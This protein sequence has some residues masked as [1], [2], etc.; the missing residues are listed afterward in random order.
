MIQVCGYFL[1]DKVFKAS[2]SFPQGHNRWYKR[3]GSSA[4]YS[5]KKHP[6]YLNGILYFGFIIVVFFVP[7][8]LNAESPVQILIE[9]VKDIELENVRTALALP[10]GFV[11]DGTINE[12]WLEYFMWQIPAKTREALKPLGFYDSNVTVSSILKDKD[13][14]EIHVFVEPGK[15][16]RVTSINVDIKGPGKNEEALADLAASFPLRKGGVCCF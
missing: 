4:F 6:G 12:K 8:C 3:K 9:G 2:E 10:A 1:T 11:E 14:R 13:T 5:E 7:L 15:A 16:V